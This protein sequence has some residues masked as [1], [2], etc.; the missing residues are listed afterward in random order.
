MA[1]RSARVIRLIAGG[2]HDPIA[3]FCGGE[4]FAHTFTQFPMRHAAECVSCGVVRVCTIITTPRTP[5]PRPNP[6]PPV[7]D[8]WFYGF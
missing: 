4:R 2:K 7:D 8:G 6:N 3:C 1:R 5:P